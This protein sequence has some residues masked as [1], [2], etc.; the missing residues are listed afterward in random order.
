MKIYDTSTLPPNGEGLSLDEVYWLYNG[1]D[2]CLTSEIRATLY[3]HLDE[4]SRATYHRTIQLQAPFLEMMLRG[5]LINTE[6]VKH[7][8]QESEKTLALLQSRFDRLCIEG[9][10]LP[11]K[12][13]WASP[14]QLKTFFYGVLGLKEIRKRNA[15]GIMAASVDRETLEKLSTNFVAEIFCNF[16]LSMRDI[17]KRISF[18]K[19]PRDADNKIRCNFNLAGTNTGRVSSSFSDFGTGTNLQNIDR[20]LRYVFV[21]EPGKAFINL[22]LEQADPRNIGA[23]VWDMFY[24][25]RGAEFAGA[26]LDACESGD[27]HTLVCRMAWPE[28]PWG[29]NP[30][31]FRAI[32]NQTAYRTYSY[33][34]LAKKLG[35][36]SNYLGQPGTM[37]MHTKVPVE[38]IAAFQRNY[39]AAFPCIPA[40]HKETIRRLQTTGSLTHLLGRRRYF[41]KRLDAQSTINAAIAYCPQGMTGDEINLGILNLWRDPRFELLVQVHDSILLQVDQTQLNE[42]VPLAI[43]LLKV[44]ITLAGGRKFHAP[45]EAKVGW[46]WGDF[47]PDNPYGLAKWKG[48]ETRLPPAVIIP[49]RRVSIRNYL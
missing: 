22:D 39:F 24:E 15:N 16:I 21:P 28:L 43:E 23:L 29:N 33:R 41:F 27:L 46:N 44:E 42:L 25:T 32:A 18:L 11:T 8:I 9:L 6:H 38:Q 26:Y 3:E 45:V 1:L 40:W 30:A 34:D 7:V 36:G 12:F 19:T 14:L 13:N 4:T 2:C 20:N 10:G 47:G 5:V 37:A 49:Q 17:Q 48:T 31:N 35:N